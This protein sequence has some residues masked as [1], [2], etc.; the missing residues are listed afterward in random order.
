MLMS[1]TILPIQA[2]LP[3]PVCLQV[4]GMTCDHCRQRVE[5]VAT[6]VAGVVAAQVDLAAGTLTVSGG[7][8]AAVIAAVSAAGYPAR[9][10]EVQ[11][12]QVRLTPLPIFRPMA[13]VPAAPSRP[14][15]LQVADMHC[16]S[17]V[18]RVEQ[19]IM[20]V[21]GVTG[22]EVNLLEKSAGVVGGDPVQVAEAVAAAG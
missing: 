7:E 18:R 1:N 3:V 21:A 8:P 19:A 15:R 14:Y 2:I 22:A 9:L 10:R 12:E 11:E 16:A 4:E 13:E 20:A 6:A 5:T 17:C